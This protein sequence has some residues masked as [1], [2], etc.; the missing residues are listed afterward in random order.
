MQFL[1]SSVI[2]LRSARHR[3]A[4]RGGGAEV[5]L[6]PMVHV[7]EA[8]FFDAVYT[9]AAAHDFVIYEGVGSRIARRLT[10][11]YRWIGPARLGLV[12]QPRER[13]EAH[14]KRAIRADMDAAEFEACWRE[15]TWPWRLAAQVAYPAA[16]LWQRLTATRGS[17]ARAGTGRLSVARRDTDLELPQ[18]A[19][20]ARAA[21]RARRPAVRNARAGD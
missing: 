1:E 14:G 15:I 6:F 7:G 11:S 19:I 13:F 5:T 21:D 3:L 2:G 4:C 18:R 16:G 20:F 17:L 10:A 12:V 8:G 9:E